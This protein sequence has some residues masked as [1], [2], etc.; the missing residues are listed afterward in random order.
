MYENF[1]YIHIDCNVGKL[2][3]C[4]D[5]PN[6]NIHNLAA[7]AQC[8]SIDEVPL[9][10][11]DSGKETEEFI[12]SYN[13]NYAYFLTI[14]NGRPE[15]DEEYKVFKVD[16]FATSQQLRKENYFIAALEFD[17][18][19]FKDLLFCNHLNYGMKN[20]EMRFCNL[21]NDYMYFSTNKPAIKRCVLDFQNQII[22]DS[23]QKL[24]GYLVDK[25]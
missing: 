11:S 9:N 17:E 14:G 6:L 18:I 24:D 4:K 2:L 1:N 5:D 12:L 25:W 23:I 22:G 8:Q 7:L 21:M 3:I 15:Y 20:F 19:T 10:W 13:I 16:D